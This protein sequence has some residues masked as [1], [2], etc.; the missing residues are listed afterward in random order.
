[1]KSRIFIAIVTLGLIGVGVW[2]AVTGNQPEPSSA[3]KKATTAK[4]SAPR[5]SV[6]DVDKSKLP[7]RFPTELPIE[8]GAAITYNYN[9]MNSKGMFQATREFVSAKSV[10]DNF[11]FYQDVLK[12]SNWTVSQAIDDTQHRQKLLLATKDGNRLNIRIYEDDSL[13]KVA[14]S[15][16]TKP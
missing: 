8:A 16:E 11:A 2:Y 4:P 10:D 15:N 7:E 13:V 9:A 3:P 6:T 5:G 12:K 1:M 14:I